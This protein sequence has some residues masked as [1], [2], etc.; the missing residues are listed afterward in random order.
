MDV[1]ILSLLSVILF[2]SLILVSIAYLNIKAAKKALEAYIRLSQ[3]LG[4][5]NLVGDEEPGEGCCGD[6]CGCSGEDR[7]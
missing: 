4:Q 1:I 3:A 2:I 6:C 7:K 5:Y